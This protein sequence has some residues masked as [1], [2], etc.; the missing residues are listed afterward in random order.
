MLNLRLSPLQPVELLPD[1]TINLNLDNKTI[2]LLFN[3]C[4]DLIRGIETLQSMRDALTK[5]TITPAFEALFSSTL[6]QQFGLIISPTTPL[7]IANE[8]IS[9]TIHR[10]VESVQ[11]VLARI[12]SWF[13]NFAQ[14][15]LDTN[16]RY[17]HQIGRI[18]R[19]LLTSYPN[20]DADAFLQTNIIGRPYPLYKET[21]N[22]VAS[23]M[24]TLGSLVIDPKTINIKALFG[25]DLIKCKFSFTADGK[26]VSP[27]YIEY[28]EAPAN[29][30]FWTTA[31]VYEFKNSLV[32]NLLN[33]NLPI[34]KIVAEMNTAIEKTNK[35][36]AALKEQETD[37]L[38]LQLQRQLAAYRC[39]KR[40][41]DY[42]LTTTSGLCYQYITMV[43]K[44]TYKK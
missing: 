6:E 18:N 11:R 10:F 30:L 20:V 16:E 44:F 22:A 23:M 32:D 3:E 29:M 12:G 14:T 31:K 35:E 28:R 19:K 17:R 36:C 39:L 1:D 7:A 41:C 43:N 2:D 34:K 24:S 38:Y 9:S 25:A 26:L 27:G 42:C 5:H 33:N 21:V 37:T 40:I 13:N 8:S 4:E 15:W